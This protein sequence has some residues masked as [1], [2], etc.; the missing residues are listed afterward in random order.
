MRTLGGPAMEMASRALSVQA[1]AG[2]ARD[3]RGDCDADWGL[4][5]CVGTDAEDERYYPDQRKSGWFMAVGALG[6]VLAARAS[7]GGALW[8]LLGAGGGALLGRRI[9]GPC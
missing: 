6:G 2:R 5:G 3:W 4:P 1:R 7:G 9:F 8:M